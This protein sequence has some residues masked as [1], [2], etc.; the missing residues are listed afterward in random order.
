MN[1][2][3]T[4]KKLIANKKISFVILGVFILLVMGAMLLA[5]YFSQ[6][7]LA[8]GNSSAAVVYFVSLTGNDNNAG[9][10]AAPFKT[11]A[12][13]ISVLQPGDELQVMPGTYTEK[14][15]INKSGTASAYIKITGVPGGAKPVIDVGNG[16][17]YGIT[18]AAS[19]KYL[20]VEN[21]EIKNT[22]TMGASFSGQYIE[23]RKLV[24]HNT[25]DHGLYSDGQHIIIDGNEVYMSNLNYQSRTASSGWGSGIKLR[26]NSDDVT[27][28]NNYSHNNYGEGIA[29]TRTKNVVIKDNKVFDNYAVQIYVDNSINTTVERNFMG[30][31]A[32]TGFEYLTGQ[33]PNGVAIGEEQYDSWGAQLSDIMIRNN[34]VINCSTGLA[35]WTG[36][37]ANGGLKNMTVAYNT[38]YGMTKT[39][40]TLEVDP[41]KTQNSIIQNNI[42]HNVSGGKLCA[43]NLKTGI[44]LGNNVWVGNTAITECSGTNDI[45]VTD[46]KFATTPNL[47]TALSVKLATGSPA[48]DAGTVM[49]VVPTDYLQLNRYTSTSPKGDIGAFEFNSTGSGA[50]CG[51]NIVETGEVCDDGGTVN[52]DQC[53]SDCLHKCTSPQIWNGTACV[54]PTTSITCYRCTVST[55]DQDS[56]EQYTYTGTACPAGSTNQPGACASVATGGHCPV[57]AVTCDSFTYTDW[58]A[59]ST[60]GKQTRTVVSA[61]PAGCTGGNPVTEQTCTPGGGVSCGPV[62]VSNPA[63]YRLTLL[64]FAA[65]AQAYGQQCTDDTNI[66]ATVNVPKTLVLKASPTSTTQNAVS[67]NLSTVG[68]QIIGFTPSVNFPISVPECAGGTSFTASSVCISL[69]KSTAIAAGEE[70]GTIT[71]KATAVGTATLTKTASFAYSDGISSVSQP[72]TLKSYMAG[73]GSKDLNGDSKVSIADFAGFAQKYNQPLCY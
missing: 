65:F 23:I 71:F 56:C 53:S 11:F 1:I 70:L 25:G 36:D 66:Y 62:D 49:A 38:F 3:R 4:I 14:M 32:N 64:D 16:S 12:K 10:S 67:I 5:V 37:V 35:S 44:T 51:N 40:L 55:T 61:S 48:I 31:N 2:D 58:S 24:I 60:S 46:A 13:G 33:R 27:I 39:S 41:Y 47:T 50:V 45:I 72:G 20:K 30:C 69:A 26:V 43:L 28:L 52:N 59:C 68:M 7:G 18:V 34:I 29:A 73:C 8:P 54:T 21:F 6:L 63:D 57:S 15:N 22:S 17:G 19:Y 9:T 42:F